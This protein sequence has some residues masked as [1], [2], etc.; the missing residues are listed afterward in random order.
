[1][2][3]RDFFSSMTRVVLACGCHMGMAV[4]HPEEVSVAV[5]HQSNAWLGVK[6]PI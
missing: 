2:C 5:S 6:D 4:P 1:M 3:G